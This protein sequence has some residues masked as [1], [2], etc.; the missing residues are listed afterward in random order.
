MKKTVSF[1]AAIALLFCFSLLPGCERAEEEEESSSAAPSMGVSGGG[2]EESTPAAS[3]PAGDVRDVLAH[4]VVFPYGADR[5]W[6]HGEAY[7]LEL[8]TFLE[9]GVLFIPVP[10]AAVMLGGSFVRLGD[11]YYLNKGGNVTVMMEDYNVLLV[12]STSYVMK[13]TPKI[14][15]GVFCLP[16]E[17]LAKALSMQISKSPAGEIC[18][19]ENYSERLS[20]EL[21]HAL[22]IELGFPAGSD[23]EYEGIRQLADRYGEDYGKLERLAVEEKL[24]IS[25]KNGIPSSVTIG[26]DGEVLLQE[27]II[28]TPLPENTMFVLKRK[29]Q[30]TM[31]CH[32]KSGKEIAEPPD[33]LYTKELKAATGR[34]MELK[35]ACDILGDPTA[36]GL[37]DAYLEA[38]GKSLS[39]EA[40]RRDLESPYETGLFTE[41]NRQTGWKTLFAQ[42]SVG[43][44]L[45]FSAAG[46][47]PEYGYFNHSALIIEK[48]EAAGTLH[49]LHA[50]GAEYGVGADLE[51]DYLAEE[52]FETLD[53]YRSYGTVF[54][55]RA[56]ALTP[57]EAENMVKEAYETYNGYQFGYGGRMG[58]EEVNCTELID[59]SY[60]MAGVDVIDGDYDSRL[61]EVLKGNTRNLVLIPDDLLFSGVTTVIA[62][63]KR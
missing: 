44:F 40:Y 50:R 54:L 62:V 43:D 13:C 16:A 7:P 22:R 61:K 42:A 58:L 41:E 28:N 56:G 15:D 29:S 12:N 33:V 9:D 6:I 55:C 2:G 24:W 34:Y 14:K 26:D 18:V 20:N 47:G 45:V 59:E 11:V 25:D 53:Y 36:R 31:L 51:M 57:S 32:I 1:L 30:G 52:S 5:V 10:T 23:R 37:Q 63:W 4:T 35:A 3:V 60:R 21:L 39:A 19:F 27:Y 46:A 48:D 38:I 8:P 49:L 17:G